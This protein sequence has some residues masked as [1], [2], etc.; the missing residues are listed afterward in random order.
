MLPD[1]S[2]DAHATGRKPWLDVPGGTQHDSPSAQGRGRDDIIAERLPN[3]THRAH[4]LY[5]FYMEVMVRIV[6][7]NSGPHR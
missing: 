1:I 4:E 5:T 7:V 6:S 3:A 2:K